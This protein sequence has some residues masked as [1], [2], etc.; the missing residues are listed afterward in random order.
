MSKY[1]LLQSTPTNSKYKLLRFV[2]FIGG[3]AILQENVRVFGSDALPYFIV[4]LC[5]C[6]VIFLP[7]YFFLKGSS[8]FQLNIYLRPEMVPQWTFPHSKSKMDPMKSHWH[9][10]LEMDPSRP[11]RI[12]NQKWIPSRSRTSYFITVKPLYL[13]YFCLVHHY[14]EA[15][16]SFTTGPYIYAPS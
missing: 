15:H 4:C 6:C 2:C 3:C 13:L 14:C 12:S 8:W 16:V 11:F 5:F 10:K 1:R 7:I 9:F